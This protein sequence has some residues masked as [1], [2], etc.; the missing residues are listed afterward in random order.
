MS[1]EINTLP[2]CTWS[3][4]AVSLYEFIKHKSAPILPQVAK[5]YMWGGDRSRTPGGLEES[6]SG[7]LTT[8]EADKDQ[9]GD[10]GVEEKT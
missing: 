6:I 4:E 9:G 10:S 3:E 8:Q 1:G 7:I 2:E 5:F